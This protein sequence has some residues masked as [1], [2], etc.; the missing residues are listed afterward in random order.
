MPSITQGRNPSRQSSSSSSPSHDSHDSE[1]TLYDPRTLAHLPTR[2]QDPPTSE[3]GSRAILEYPAPAHSPSRLAVSTS[4]TTTHLPS[5]TSQQPSQ[6]G[7]PPALEERE[8]WS[9]PPVMPTLRAHARLCAVL[10]AFFI[11]LSGLIV[12]WTV[13]MIHQLKTGSSSDSQGSDDDSA[14]N[15]QQEGNDD[16]DEGKWSGGVSPVTMVI[17]GIFII[18][19]V[20]FLALLIRQTSLVL[21]LFRPPPPPHG[22]NPLSNPSS[23]SFLPPWLL[24][25]LPSYIETI[26]GRGTGTGDV[27]DRYIVGES[28]P[29]YGH[30]RGSKLLLRSESRGGALRQGEITHSPTDSVGSNH[31]RGEPLS[32]DVSEAMTPRPGMTGLSDQQ[33]MELGRDQERRAEEERRAGVRDIVEKSHYVR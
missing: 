1:Q 10:L 32:Y 3:Q 5:P 30:N 19:I 25:R 26:G 13:F 7:P 17:D 33:R 18:A 31:S 20:L 4:R 14:S 28:L 24:P 16:D 6:R 9:K 22:P 23:H 29:V 8:A 27:E 2:S 11:A 21:S 15:G 12:G